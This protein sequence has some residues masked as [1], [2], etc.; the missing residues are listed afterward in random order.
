MSEYLSACL[1]QLLPLAAMMLQVEP[2]QQQQLLLLVVLL[3]QVRPN[4]HHARPVGCRL[5]DR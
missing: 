4:Q 2:Q 3:M 5:L 1:S